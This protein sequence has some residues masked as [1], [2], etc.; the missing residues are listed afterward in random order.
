MAVLRR[1]RGAGTGVSTRIGI[2][3]AVHR[4]LRFFAKGSRYLSGPASLNRGV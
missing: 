1:V 4:P 3:R 2:S